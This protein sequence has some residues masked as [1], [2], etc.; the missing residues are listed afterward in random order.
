MNKIDWAKMPIGTNT[1]HGK[2]IQHVE[3]FVYTLEKSQYHDGYSVIG[4]HTD[5]L[6][7]IPA[8]EWTYWGGGEC[9]VPAGVMCHVIH[10]CGFSSLA[11][12]TGEKIKWKHIADKDGN[13]THTMD[14]IAYRV[15][16]FDEEVV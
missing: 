8:T 12:Q 6:E 1:N 3:E 15:V 10:R 2:I 14:V 9:P 7:L 13:W 16:G 11:A 4:C 5:S